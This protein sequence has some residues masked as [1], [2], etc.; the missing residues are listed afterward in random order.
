MRAALEVTRGGWMEG[1]HFG[2]LLEWES[3]RGDPSF[4]RAGVFPDGWLAS[5]WRR[6]FVEAQEAHPLPASLHM[7]AH[8]NFRSFKG[9]VPGW[10]SNCLPQ[11]H[12]CIPALPGR[13]E[14]KVV[15]VSAWAKRQVAAYFS[16]SDGSGGSKGALHPIFE[17]FHVAGAMCCAPPSHKAGGRAAGPP[18]QRAQSLLHCFWIF[19][20]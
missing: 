3:D 10:H 1:G 9:L 4:P 13:D 7:A 6:Q 8:P 5:G 17:R 11:P 19:S 12:E 14:L 16:R 2:T 15:S 18:V 20:P